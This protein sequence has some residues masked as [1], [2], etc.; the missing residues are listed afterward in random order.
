MKIFVCHVNTHQRMISAEED[1]NNQV[2]DLTHS[3][4]TGQPLSL[5]T[6]SLL[7]KIMNKV[8]TMV[9]GMETVHGLSTI[10]YHLPRLAY[11]HC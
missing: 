10:D 7:N 8:A 6:L 4:D 9:A 2:D 5:A 11:D 3:V 1:F